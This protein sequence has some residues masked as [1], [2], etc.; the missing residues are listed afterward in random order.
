MNIE[1]SRVTDVLYPFSGLTQISSDILRKAGDRGTAVHEICDAIINGLGVN[2]MAE[3][4]GYID[5]FMSFFQ[6]KS[7]LEKPNRFYCDQY[8]ITGECDG[9]YKSEKGITLFD[10]KTSGK[11]GKTWRLQGSAYAYLA[12][13]KGITVNEIVFVKLDKSGKEPKIFSYEYDFDMFLKCLEMYNHFFK[14]VKLDYLD[15][16]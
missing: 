13:Q 4:Q 9:L 11:E 12:K 15:Y 10:L 8:M 6:G 3:F 16:L 7:F 1:Y 5:S 2:K 14:D